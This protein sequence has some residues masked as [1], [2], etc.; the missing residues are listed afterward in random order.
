MAKGTVDSN[1]LNIQAGSSSIAT[2]ASNDW[3]S[4]TITFP[5]PFTKIPKVIAIPTIQS[6]S[7]VCLS[8][9]SVNGFTLRMDNYG[10]A[11]NNVSFNW[12]A[13]EV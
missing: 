10:Q 7:S 8:N 1:R 2:I 4:K 13:I 12:V 11:Q 9:I 5:K 6:R 3:T